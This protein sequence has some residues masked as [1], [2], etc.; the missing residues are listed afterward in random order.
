[1]SKPKVTI[2][3]LEAHVAALEASYTH[4]ADIYNA[5]QRRMEN[6]EAVR[7]YPQ[8]FE[9]TPAPGSRRAA[10]AAAREQAMRTG[11][12]VLVA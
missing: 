2:A 6:L 8:P 10:M 3:Q 4:L 12:S 1:M 11:K 9:A 5:L 7:P